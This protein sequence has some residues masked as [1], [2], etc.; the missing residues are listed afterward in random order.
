MRAPSSLFQKKSSRNVVKTDFALFMDDGSSDSFNSPTMS[1]GAPRKSA[2]SPPGGRSSRK[3]MGGGRKTLRHTLTVQFAD[4]SENDTYLVAANA[5]LSQECW[6]SPQELVHFKKSV[7]RLAKM[8]LRKPS[9][10]DCKYQRILAST[11]SSCR[12]VAG[13]FK[14]ED[15]AQ[16]GSILCPQDQKDLQKCLEVEQ[17]SYFRLGLHG[18]TVKVLMEERRSTQK[19][20]IQKMVQ[21][22]ELSMD[23]NT[24]IT[25]LECE[26]EQSSRGARLFALEMGRALAASCQQV[27]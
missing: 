23:A 25:K 27:Q 17:T 15:F 22:Q 11:F 19:S 2:M 6:Y 20:R 18:M 4:P 24:R 3:S 9:P 16:G 5:K 26:L 1:V 10:A 14:V 21:I 13:A 8:V 7:V 12:A